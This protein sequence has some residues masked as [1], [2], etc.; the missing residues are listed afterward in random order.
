MRKTILLIL[1]LCSI[2][3]FSQEYP[4]LTASTRREKKHEFVNYRINLPKSSQDSV[5]KSLK[6]YKDD[7][8]TYTEAYADSIFNAKTLESS[9]YKIVTYVDTVSNQYYDVLHKRSNEELDADIKALQEKFD[10]DE[11][12]R[13]QLKGSTVNDLTMTDTQGNSYTAAQLRGKVVIID[14]W[15][16]TCA[17]CIQEMPDLN[18]IKEDFGT[19]EVAYFGVTYDEKPKVEKFLTRVK[20]NYS[21]IPNARNLTDRFGITFYPTTLVIDKEGK[22]V[23]TGDLMGLKDKPKEI[24]RLLKKLISGKR[25]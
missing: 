10:L 17:P 23:Y 9:A 18:K 3:A 14:F 25:K 4:F 2:T 5:L 15:F 20:Y 12:N 13:K 8:S 1:L 7:G 21:I 22:I 24:R 16:T 19:D 11:K 6:R